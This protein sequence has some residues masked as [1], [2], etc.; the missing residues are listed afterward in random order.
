MLNSLRGRRASI[1][2]IQ[3]LRQSDRA[4][5]SSTY[6]CSKRKLHLPLNVYRSLL[7]TCCVLLHSRGNL[8]CTVNALTAVYRGPRMK[9]AVSQPRRLFPKKKRKEER[10]REEGRKEEKERRR[11]ELARACTRASFSSR[12][13]FIPT[14][15]IETRHRL[16]G[17]LL[18]LIPTRSKSTCLVDLFIGNAFE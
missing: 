2:A 4:Q 9:N 1:S 13:L 16:F 10:R 7:L 8:I 11:V 6:S 14:N 12:I 3:L 15:F 17:R 18:I 5:I